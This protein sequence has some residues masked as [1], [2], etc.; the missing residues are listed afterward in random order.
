M[1]MNPKDEN[2]R[3]TK[4]DGPVVP[5]SALYRMLHEV[6]RAV[7]AKLFSEAPRGPQSNATA[8]RKRQVDEGSL[9]DEH[10]SESENAN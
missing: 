7:A 9:A 6:A 8:T 1:S 5:G 2:E 3:I 10:Q 4:V